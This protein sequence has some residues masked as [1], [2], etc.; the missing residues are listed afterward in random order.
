MMRPRRALLYV[1]GSD[2]PKMQKA[3]GMG[4]DCVCLDLED[5]V[6]PDKK[7]EARALA[8]QALREL[9]FGLSERLV[10]IN[11]AGS[12][13][14][15][16]DLEAL[17]PARPDGIVLPKAADA[18]QVRQISERIAA[19]EQ[20][21]GL[22]TLSIRL[23][24]QIES[25]R[26]LVNIKEI[27]SADARLNALIFGSEDFAYDVG[28]RRTPEGD[29]I[30]YARSKVVAHAAA[31]GLQAIDMLWVDFKDGAG[32][33]R[34]AAQGAQLGYSG[35]QVI[36]PDQIAPVQRAFTPS[37]AELAAAQRIVDAYTENI[38]EGR[39]VFALDGRM[40]DLPIVK[41]AQR[42]LA[43]GGAIGQ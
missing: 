15:T 25:A 16:D 3:V 36:H 30:F 19:F 12:G 35:M 27:A 21:Q 13:L 14:E 20:K 41:A 39:G 22:K 33:Q 2:W 10:R 11:A 34:L 32:L 4:A 18:D 29:E 23:I 38:K 1:P 9:G 37:A 42:V 26:G 40:V 8:S 6:A 24:A 28:A 5:G 7:I 17:L 43:R 31:F